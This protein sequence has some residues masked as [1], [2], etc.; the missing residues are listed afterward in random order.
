M[1]TENIQGGSAGPGPGDGEWPLHVSGTADSGQ[2][3]Q[4][5]HREL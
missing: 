5:R 3:A 4:N 2:M 1:V